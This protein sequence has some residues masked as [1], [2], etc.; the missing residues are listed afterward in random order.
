VVTRGDSKT[1]RI[2]EMLR[3]QILSRELPA[4]TKLPSH[5]DLANQFGVAPMTVRTVL[6]QLES[7]GLVS[8]E[9]GRGTF[10]RPVGVSSVLLVDEDAVTRVL[11]RAQIQKA[12]YRAI[13]AADPEEAMACLEK[14]RS[15][16]LVI[17]DVH[18][19]SKDD[20]I[21]FIQAVR[22]RWP[23]LPLAAITGFPDD[24]AGI[25]GT[26]EFPM[27]IL[28]KP[29]SPYQVDGLLRIVLNRRQA[30]SVQR[31]TLTGLPTR[32]L[33]QDRLRHTLAYARRHDQH[34]ALILLD[35]DG[36]GAINETLGHDVG[37]LLLREMADRL[38][39]HTRDSD[40]VAHLGGDH[41]AVILPSIESRDN[42]MTVANK[43][44]EDFGEG[45]A[46]GGT[47]VDIS[48]SLGISLYPFDGADPLTLHKSA[49]RALERAKRRRGPIAASA[50]ALH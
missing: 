3:D 38:S 18:M 24:L 33:F 17:S 49:E 43:I 27:L 28:S 25:F 11:L 16:S 50:D 5:L 13:E 22:R 46:A 41:F 15:I 12:G 23:D 44:I 39:K 7:E 19:P 42:A 30:Q 26:T 36:F 37:D 47:Q 2:Y 20:G 6:G 29:I 48:A 31:D 45:F 21:A 34:V 8:R 32:D 10:V 1:R 14:D 4:G 35:F 40:T 9:Q